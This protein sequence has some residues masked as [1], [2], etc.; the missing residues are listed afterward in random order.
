MRSPEEIL[1]QTN[2]LAGIF[3]S[4]KGYKITGEKFYETGRENYHPDEGYCWE[5]ACRAQELLTG[6]DIYDVLQELEMEMD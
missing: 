6:T 3:Y 2:E 4:L 1:E 5:A